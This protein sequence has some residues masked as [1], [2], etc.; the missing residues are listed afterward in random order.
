MI[1]DKDDLLA[2]NT[3]SQPRLLSNQSTTSQQ[4]HIIFYLLLLDLQSLER[5]I[6]VKESDWEHVQLIEEK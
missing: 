2:L 5:R 1:D 4:G 6:V 3:A